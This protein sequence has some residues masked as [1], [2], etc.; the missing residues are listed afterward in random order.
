MMP[1]SKEQEK[2]ETK[3]HEEFMRAVIPDTKVYVAMRIYDYEGLVVIGVYATE[4]AAMEACAVDK[5]EAKTPNGNAG[6]DWDVEGFNVQ[7]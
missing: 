4:K 5:A 3:A 1:K 7:G 2:A 6:N